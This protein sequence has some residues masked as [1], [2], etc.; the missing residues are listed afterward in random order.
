MYVLQ[1]LVDGNENARR[2]KPWRSRVIGISQGAHCWVF[3]SRISLIGQIRASGSILLQKLNMR[4][5]SDPLAVSRLWVYKICS[6]YKSANKHVYCNV[7][8]IAL[9]SHKL[10]WYHFPPSSLHLQPSSDSCDH[11]LPL[12]CR[13]KCKIAKCSWSHAVDQQCHTFFLF[14]LLCIHTFITC[15]VWVP[16]QRII[17]MTIIHHLSS[18]T[19][20]SADVSFRQQHLSLIMSVC[21]CVCHISK[22]NQDMSLPC[23]RW[24][25]F[26]VVASGLLLRNAHARMLII[27]AADTLPFS[28]HTPFPFPHSILLSHVPLL[29]ILCHSVKSQIHAEPIVL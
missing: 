10:L 7:P 2:A 16:L 22:E 13:F 14:A 26:H 12:W 27:K 24:P 1:T 19:P 21:A 11:P 18:P 5:A 6:K 29:F 15:C 8:T 9:R 23:Y 28:L 25:S 20:I 4:Y 17:T 3:A